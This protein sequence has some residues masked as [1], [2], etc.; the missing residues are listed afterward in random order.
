MGKRFI[1]TLVCIIAMGFL[2]TLTVN[3]Q[4]KTTIMTSL[5]SSQV[6]VG[7][8]F[9]VY[10]KAENVYDLY[11]VQFTINYNTELLDLVSNTLDMKSGFKSFGGETVDKSKGIVT[12]PLI[13]SSSKKE[14]LKDQLIGEL[15]FKAK[16]KGGDIFNMSNVKAVNSD[17]VVISKNTNYSSPINVVSSGIISVDPVTEPEEEVTDPGN[18]GNNSSGNQNENT[19]NNEGTKPSKDTFSDEED[20]DVAAGSGESEKSDSEENKKE[21]EAIE[22]DGRVVALNEQDGQVLNNDGNK[23]KSTEG[24]N[25]NSRAILT[26]LF[27]LAMILVGISYKTEFI[28]KIKEKIKVK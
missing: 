22:A 5:D 9:K 14:L 23:D 8:E 25:E 2:S 16:S 1:S 28:K 4:E 27:G 12:Y 3:A 15:V 11:G 17:A 21:S 26:I 20:D 7:Q 10:V 13:N 6:N 24:K 18:S 19:K